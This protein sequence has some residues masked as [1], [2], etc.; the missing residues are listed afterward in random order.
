MEYSTE[1]KIYDFLGAT[2]WMAMIF[3]MMSL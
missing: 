3:L 2:M 1:Q